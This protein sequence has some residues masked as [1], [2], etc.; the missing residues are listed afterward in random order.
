[1]KA[2]EKLYFENIDDTTCYPLSD[3]LNDARLEGLREVTLVEAIP[4]NNNP[5]YIYCGLA[6]EVGERS[7]CKK[8]ECSSYSSTSGRGKCKH[9]GNLYTHG[10]EIT[11]DVPQD[12]KTF[13]DLIKNS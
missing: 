4:D 7:E 3:R 6:G 11:F 9:R 5:E 13:N 1:M 8:A 2:K 12:S 10:D